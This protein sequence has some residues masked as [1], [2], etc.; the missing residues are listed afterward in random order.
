MLLNNV[1]ALDIFEPE[2][3]NNMPKTG[4]IMCISN[5]GSFAILIKSDF[6]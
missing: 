1:A 2:A 5:I 6:I 3:N 4:I